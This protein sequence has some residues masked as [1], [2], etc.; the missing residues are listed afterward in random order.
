[1]EDGQ[2]HETV[3]MTKQLKAERP[4]GLD[5]YL[6]SIDDNVNIFLCCMQ[7]YVLNLLKINYVNNYYFVNP[8][9]KL[10]KILPCSSKKSTY[11]ILPIKWHPKNY[12]MS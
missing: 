5:H 11:K 4:M 6:F 2:R 9:E 12:I 1:M 3:R 10:N 7:I 8:L